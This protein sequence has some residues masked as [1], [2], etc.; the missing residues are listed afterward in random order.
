M[1]VT[2]YVPRPFPTDD[3][4]IAPFWSDVNTARSGTITYGIIT[5]SSALAK[6]EMEIWR[7]FPTHSTFTPTYLYVATWE[8]VGYYGQEFSDSEV[9]CYI[10]SHEMSYVSLI[11]LYTPRAR[12][13][14]LVHA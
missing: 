10:A 8:D 14:C 6:A 13:L 5:E 12:E 9:S 11:N 4:L 7:A 3:I 2:D 1:Q